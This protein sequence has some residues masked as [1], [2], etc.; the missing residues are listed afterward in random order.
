MENR[1]R[2]VHLHVMVTPDELALF[3]LL[4]LVQRLC[5]QLRGR[6][7]DGR[8]VGYAVDHV[9]VLLRGELGGFQISEQQEN[10]PTGLWMPQRRNFLT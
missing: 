10:Y 1:K 4:Y 6:G 2:N 5:V 7:W 9:A 3:G 8:I